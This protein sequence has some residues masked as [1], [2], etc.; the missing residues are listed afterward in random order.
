M[1]GMFAGAKK[2]DADISNWNT[3][4]VYNMWIMFN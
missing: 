2:F 3:S 1:D 4:K